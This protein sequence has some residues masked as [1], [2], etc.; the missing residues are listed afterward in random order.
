MFLL[1]GIEGIYFNFPSCRLR[2]EATIALI[3]L[4]PRD[5]LSDWA[6]GDID[7]DGDSSGVVET[8]EDMN[9]K[10]NAIWR[11]YLIDVLQLQ[12]DICLFRN[13]RGVFDEFWNCRGVFE[14]S[15]DDIYT[16]NTI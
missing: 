15:N 7:G 3:E 10:G 4:E 16:Y 6:I 1:T 11:G 14:N 5:L 8:G 9:G 13:Y 12:G 2:K